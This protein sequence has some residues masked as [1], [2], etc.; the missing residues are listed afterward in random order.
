MKAGSAPFS[1]RIPTVSR[2]PRHGW[3]V[4]Q[5]ARCGQVRDAQLPAGG[6]DAFLPGLP[7]RATPVDEAPPLPNVLGRSE[8]CRIRG[9]AAQA[10]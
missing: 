9:E 5:A 10:Q 4:R 7:Q 8:L 1:A 2:A 3:L 6:R